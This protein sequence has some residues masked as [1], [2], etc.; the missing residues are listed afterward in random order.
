[1][2]KSILMGAVIAIVL[3][4]VLGVGGY[5]YLRAVEGRADPLQTDRVVLIFES[6]AEDGAT[7]ATLISM[8]AD[9]RMTDVSPDTSV[10]VPGSSSNRLG[11]VFVFGGGSGVARVLSDN[12]SGT[13]ASFVSVPQSVWRAAVEASGGVSVSI[14]EQLT[15]F[16]GTRL[17]TIQSGAQMLTADQVA[18]VL[19]GQAFLSPAQSSAVREELE[20]K[21]GAA[22]VVMKPS[23][24]GLKSD[25]TPDGLAS[26]LQDKLA[27]ALD[28]PR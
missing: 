15:V 6:P 8:V 14:P 16:D 4:V 9:G 20:R 19:R 28:A 10:T 3:V 22:V 7:V 12:A 21:L 5:V 27:S 23:P 25:L 17:T 24:T 1:M 18:A 2:G 11:D 26:W 13:P